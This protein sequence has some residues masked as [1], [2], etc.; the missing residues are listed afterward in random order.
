[1]KTKKIFY[2]KKV[3]RSKKTGLLEVGV[4]FSLNEVIFHPIPKKYQEKYEEG[5]KILGYFGIKHET[6][7]KDK[8]G[9]PIIIQYF[10]PKEKTSN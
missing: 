8:R 2:K 7:K 5:Q 6:G 4:N 9:V 10:I 3:K 1:M